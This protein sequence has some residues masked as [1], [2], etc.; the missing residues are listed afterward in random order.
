MQ[1]KIKSLGMIKDDRI[2]RN[3]YNSVDLFV[4]PSKIE[5]FGQVASGPYCVEHQ[6]WF[7]K[8]WVKRYCQ[9]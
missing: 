8:H 7:F 9:K 2:L 4:L 5:A 1:N 3:I 6:C